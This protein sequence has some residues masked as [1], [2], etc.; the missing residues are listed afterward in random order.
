[1]K[2]SPR[3][4]LAIEH[5]TIRSNK[6][7][8][9]FLHKRRSEN[10][11]EADCVTV[12]DKRGEKAL[13]RPIGRY[14]TF[15][16]NTPENES[17]SSA[18]TAE[19]KRML[20]KNG[21]RLLCVGLGNRA[22]TADAIGPM[23]V[24]RLEIT[25]HLEN[26]NGNRL[27]AIAPGVLG[28][29]GIEGFTLIKAACEA[30]NATALLCIDALAAQSTKRLYQTVQLGTS[31]IVPGSGIGNHRHALTEDTLGVPVIAIGVPTVV[32]SATLLFDTLTA[33]DLSPLVPPLEKALS[34]SEPFF[35][36]PPDADSQSE[37]LAG[38][39]ASAIN[40]L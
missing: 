8:S 22:I 5:E 18:L 20:D 27:F 9:G 39:I 35:V 1:M 37:A 23:T 24:D 19:L 12:L 10:G 33:L 30:A 15:T 13:D 17:L 34:E 40:S 16:F 31:G 36:T 25:G 2:F 28:K 21:K 11:I 14:V 4:D 38:V 6:P 26:E 32:S 29:T 7:A 3:T